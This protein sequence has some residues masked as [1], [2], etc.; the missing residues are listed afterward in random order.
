VANKVRYEKKISFC[1]STDCNWCLCSNSF[2]L[3]QSIIH[4]HFGTNLDAYGN[5]IVVT[6]SNTMNMSQSKVFVF[7]KTVNDLI[8]TTYFEPT[9][10]VPIDSFGAAVSINNDFIAV[11]SPLHS[12]AASHAGAVY[13]YRKVSGTWQ[14]FQKITAF[15]A[16]PDDFFGRYVKVYNNQLFVSSIYDEPTSQPATTDNGSI[17]VY[18]FD[19]SQWSFSEKLTLANSKQFGYKIEIEN[20]TLLIATSDATTLNTIN[21]YIFNG[22]NWGF[23]SSLSPLTADE[24]IHDFTIDNN[25][26]YVITRPD[27]ATINNQKI[28]VYDNSVTNWSLNSTVIPLPDISENLISQ[29]K[30]KNNVMLVGAT[31]YILAM[32]RKSPLLFYKKIGIDWVLQNALYGNGNAGFD[33]SFGHS[34]AFTDNLAVI[35]A[36][37]ENSPLP[38][39]KAYLLDTS[40][41]IKENNFVKEIIYPNPTKDIVTISENIF[42]NLDKIEVYQLDGKLI[43]SLVMNG[44]SISL[45][46]YQS[47]IYLLKFTLKDQSYFVKKIVRE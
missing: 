25:T 1:N 10:G 44:Y 39:G 3:F 2:N 4:N 17:Y 13:L 31:D 38:Y 47:G 24:F 35:S 45:K 37:N 14:F 6:A 33:D 46:D 27:N 30:V 16:M 8:Q 12:A 32:T 34:L 21:T 22:S 43:N 15:D 29:I 23:S 9:D 5:E 18:N 41:G 28:A 7:E 42:N 20:N 36:P 26:L 19:G 11:G 40:L